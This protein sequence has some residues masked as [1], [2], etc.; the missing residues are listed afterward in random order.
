MKVL[1]IEGMVCM[2]IL[3]VVWA[4]HIVAWCDKNE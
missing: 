2:I 4:M 1:L 3:L